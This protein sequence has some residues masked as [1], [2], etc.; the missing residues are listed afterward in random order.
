MTNE[1]DLQKMAR[2][3]GERAMTESK[4][5]RMLTD[6]RL[7][8]LKS[9]GAAGGSLPEFK[10]HIGKLFETDSAWRD[11]ADDALAGKM[12]AFFETGRMPK[13]PPPV[14]EN[15]QTVLAEFATVRDA[16]TDALL[17]QGRAKTKAEVTEADR[18]MTIAETALERAGG[19]KDTF[20]RDLHD[21]V[22]PARETR[23]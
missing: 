19:N 13:E 4:L 14:D 23:N 10:V 11:A 17:A 12:L 5:D 22:W 7:R 16:L 3:L 6:E 18:L 20:L 21:A 8:W 15:E 1:I 9:R 2:R